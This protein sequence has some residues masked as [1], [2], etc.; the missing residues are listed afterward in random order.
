MI[1]TYAVRSATPYALSIA[2]PSDNDLLGVA[3]VCTVKDPTLPAL[4]DPATFGV[5][6]RLFPS[7]GAWL[8][9]GPRP[10]G[11]VHVMAGFDNRWSPTADESGPA[12]T[13]VIRVGDALAHTNPTM[14][15]GIS[16]APWA[17][18]HIADTAH[19]ADR[20]DEFARSCD[21]WTRDSPKPWFDLQVTGDRDNEARLSGTS[22]A[23]EDERARQRA[24]RFPCALEDPVVMRAWAQVR[25]MMRTPREAFAA[26]KVKGRIEKWLARQPEAARPPSGPSRD[27]WETITAGAR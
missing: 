17:A 2:F 22:G 3:L 10:V 9:T 26:A 27:T 4:R 1:S 14:T 18:R 13:G 19:H 5:L 25:H 23:V 16:L 20:P 7:T 21:R 11:E 15:Q 24:A 6:V 8:S 12:A